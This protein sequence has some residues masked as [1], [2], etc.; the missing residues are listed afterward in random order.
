MKQFK[1]A[2][3]SEESDGS[4]HSNWR[5]LDEFTV[6]LSF[7]AYLL[8]RWRSPA[9]FP[10][11]AYCFTRYFYVSCNGLLPVKYHLYRCSSLMYALWPCS[12]KFSCFVSL[13]DYSI[14]NFCNSNTFFLTDETRSK[15]WIWDSCLYKNK[16]KL[17][18]S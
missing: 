11:I 13:F 7:A 2:K 10:R 12:S 17:T 1:A 9:W 16:S 8:G 4:S 3:H 6:N 18:C 15:L 5:M 14:C